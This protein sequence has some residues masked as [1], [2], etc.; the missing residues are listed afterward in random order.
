M[1]SVLEKKRELDEQIRLTKGLNE[2][3]E[4]ALE[5][6]THNPNVVDGVQLASEL[7]RLDIVSLILGLF[8]L[9]LGVVAFC[10]FWMIK[11][12]AIEAAREAAR[13]E[14]NKKAPEMF[15]EAGKLSGEGNQQS[16]VNFSE[17]DIENIIGQATEV[18]R[19]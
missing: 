16:M 12:A 17:V 19:D 8:A 18:E 2:Q 7:G 10:G 4:R 3:L 9:I 15:Y 13:L 1:S 14:I 5:I 11:G 6:I